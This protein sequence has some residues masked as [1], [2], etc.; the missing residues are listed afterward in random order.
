VERLENHTAA[1]LA[2]TSSVAVDADDRELRRQPALEPWDI[3]VWLRTRCLNGDGWLARRDLLMRTQPLDERLTM[4]ED[5]DLFC[6]L[7]E[8]TTF[9]PVPEFLLYYR[10]HASRASADRE[11]M[12]RCHAANLVRYGYSP[13]YAY[14][15]ARRNPE[16]VPAIEAGIA[17]GRQI[18]AGREQPRPAC[19]LA[20]DGGAPVRS[21]FLPFGAPCLTEEEIQE[22][23]ATIRSG[24]IGL[25]PGTAGLFLSLISLGIGPGDEV[26][27]TPLT[28][29][30]TA[31]VIEHLGA[32]PVFAD[33]D[34]TTLN[35]DPAQVERAITPRT[36]ALLPVHFG[37]LPCDMEALRAIK[38]SSGTVPVYFVPPTARVY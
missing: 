33:I 37:G 18:R 21:S 2:Y 4:D 22:V 16:W 36:R 23:A 15:R 31:N 7:L 3:E 32:R 35:L 20:I 26:I 10:E 19:P 30:A 24:W 13:E 17:L 12:A 5:Y 28:F 1:G 6:Q 14:L 25:G 38:P 11:D 34:T 9:A 27:T 8:F 29:A